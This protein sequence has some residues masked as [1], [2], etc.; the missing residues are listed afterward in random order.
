MSKSI[1]QQT[2]HLL[3][4][5]DPMEAIRALRNPSMRFREIAA[6]AI[7]ANPLC[8]S[9]VAQC[10]DLGRVLVAQYVS[11]LN[12]HAMALKNTIAHS[13]WGFSGSTGSVRKYTCYLCRQVVD[14]D[15]N[16]YAKTRHANKAITAHMNAH[17]VARELSL[18]G[19]V[20]KPIAERYTWVMSVTQP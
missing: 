16:N 8:A 13:T 6:L 10:P 7:K 3:T 20:M 18:V 14:T 2:K 19:E 17:R 9:L 1:A 4:T 15:S 5:S 11:D 12:F